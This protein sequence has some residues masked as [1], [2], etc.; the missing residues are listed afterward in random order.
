M[1]FI[2]AQCGV[3]PFGTLGLFWPKETYHYTTMCFVSVC[4]CALWFVSFWSSGGVQCQGLR[5]E[6]PRAVLGLIKQCVALS[7]SL[8]LSLALSVS[9]CHGSVEGPRVSRS[10]SLPLDHLNKC[11]SSSAAESVRSICSRFNVE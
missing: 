7:L 6:F 10:V 8:S 3:L 9:L 4:F 5:I 1:C 11:R 2:S